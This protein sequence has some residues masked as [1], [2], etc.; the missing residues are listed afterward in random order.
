MQKE[1]IV[2]SSIGGILWYNTEHNITQVSRSFL[3]KGLPCW[4]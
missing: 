4:S 1:F 2:Y 3:G